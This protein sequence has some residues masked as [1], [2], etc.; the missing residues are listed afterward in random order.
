MERNQIN[1]RLSDQLSKLI[2]D[3]R[4][5]LSGS[6]GKIPSRSDVVR[7]ALAQYLK[8]DLSVTEIDRRKTW[9]SGA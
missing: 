5:A 2:D 7:L 6:M 3:K 1:M 8:V 4:I 9:R